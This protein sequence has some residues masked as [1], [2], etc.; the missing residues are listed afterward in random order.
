[1]ASSS[2]DPV[3]AF[4]R[5]VELQ[6][7]T[8][9]GNGAAAGVVATGSKSIASLAHSGATG[10]YTLTLKERGYKILYVGFSVQG[11]TGAAN[12]L[13]AV[14]VTINQAAKTVTVEVADL[15]KALTD[16]STS[17]TLHVLVATGRT[18]E[19]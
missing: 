18:D 1:M 7:G 13:H 6:V 11:P 16:L 12:H 14:P 19:S 15:D 17:H 5:D 10:K 4:G 8:V 9:T 3:R 2:S